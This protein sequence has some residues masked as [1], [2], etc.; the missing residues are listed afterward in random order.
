MF[1]DNAY[2]DNAYSE[3]FD[4]VFSEVFDSVHLVVLDDVYPE[5]FDR[6][7]EKSN[8]NIFRIPLASLTAVPPRGFLGAHESAEE[9][10]R[11]TLGGC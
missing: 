1:F 8:Q 6:R 5:T 11:C 10:G 7:I 9:G 3:M 2:S 4:H